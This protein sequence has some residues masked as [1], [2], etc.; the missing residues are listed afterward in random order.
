M[1]L[2]RD[3]IPNIIKES[4]KTCEYHVANHDEYKARLYEKMREELDE[5][6]N[7][8]CEEEAADMYEVLRAI[9]LL[10]T[11]P[12]E[13]VEDVA[14]GKRAQRGAFNDMIVLE[15]VSGESRGS[16]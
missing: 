13:V 12:M 1:K 4:G 16:S 7:T 5:F 14:K 11:F 8:P 3:K 15:K 10:H 9:C 6:I 2:V